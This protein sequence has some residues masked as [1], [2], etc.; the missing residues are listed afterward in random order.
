MTQEVQSPTFRLMA[1][2]EQA[3]TLNY[4]QKTIPAM[5]DATSKRGRAGTLARRPT[6]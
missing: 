4:A 5:R 6:M 1:S 2:K 3:W